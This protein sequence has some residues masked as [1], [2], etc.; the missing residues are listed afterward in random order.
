MVRASLF[1][2][3]NVAVGLAENAQIQVDS[4]LLTDFT[5]DYFFSEEFVAMRLN[6]HHHDFLEQYG[7]EKYYPAKEHGTIQFNARQEQIQWKA[8]G[9]FRFPKIGGEGPPREFPDAL[10]PVLGALQGQELTGHGEFRVD[11]KTGFASTRGNYQIMGFSEEFCIG[12]KFPGM[13]MGEAQIDAQIEQG[14]AQMQGM[15]NQMPHQDIDADG[16]TLAVFPL[17]KPNPWGVFPVAAFHLN[18]VPFGF[19]LTNAKHL[20]DHTPLMMFKEWHAGSGDIHAEGCNSDTSAVELLARPE[21]NA[22]LEM[23]DRH[24]MSTQSAFSKFTPA[25]ME[26]MKPSDVVRRAAQLEL[27]Q[28]Q[29]TPALTSIFVVAGLT[30]ALISLAA[31]AV[32][33]R[34]KKSHRE[35]LISDDA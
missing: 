32:M 34:S 3:C 33:S 20:G 25:N 12:F 10:K 11:A 24:V 22:V 17:A 23:L 31:V 1:L 5:T 18:G 21:G 8:N 29:T 15:M 6:T 28:R 35:P 19:D 14:A 9:H 27:A 4:N 13:P 16:E 30:S 26:L 2:F 7:I